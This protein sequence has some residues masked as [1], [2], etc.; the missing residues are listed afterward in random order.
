[1]RSIRGL[2][3]VKLGSNS[4]RIEDTQGVK[5]KDKDKDT[6]GLK[7]GV[8]TIKGK[9]GVQTDPDK[10]PLTPRELQKR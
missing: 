6:K 7:E 5:D 2:K 3:E 10:T 8:E 9:N 4:G 1:M